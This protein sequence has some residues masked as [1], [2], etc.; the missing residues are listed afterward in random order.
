MSDREQYEGALAAAGSPLMDCLWAFEGVLRRLHPPD[1][2]RLRDAMAPKRDAL[3]IG[4]AGLTAAEPPPALKGFHARIDAGARTLLDAL[5][6][7]V[8]DRSAAQPI[9]PVL[10]S[11]RRYTEALETLYTLHRF[12]PIGRFFVEEPFHT[13][14][15][16]LDRDPPAGVTVGLHRTSGDDARGR[17]GFCLYVPESYD[18]SSELALV[19][20][21][22][23]GSGTG[24]SFLWSWLREARGRRFAL[25]APTSR[26]PTWALAGPDLD[27][28]ALASMIDLA[29]DRWRIDRGRV[30]L[31]GLS[32]GATYALLAGLRE[33][34]PYTA[35][36]PLS[37]MLHPALQASGALQRSA[38][39]RRVYLVHGALDWMFPVQTARAA[40]EALKNAGADL[41]YREI[42]DLSH[43]YAREENA[44]ILEWFDPSLALP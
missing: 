9:L 4:L 21:L 42:D 6:T 34:S 26:G 8:D 5:A 10:A 44:R 36:A 29:C 19:V 41:V 2:A 39:G 17:G 38:A 22:H 7:F 13:R 15:E 30:L 32:D 3:A 20:A 25:L 23:G 40:A 35:L 18:A 33:D 24:R 37:G 28:A 27:A 31:T 16:E 11:M 1:L 14:L 43:T 12:P